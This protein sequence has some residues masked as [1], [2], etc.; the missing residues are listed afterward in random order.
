MSEIVDASAPSV[1]ETGASR[2]NHTNAND[3]RSPCWRYLLDACIIIA[4]GAILFW[5][6]TSQ[7]SNKYNDVT[8]YECYDISFW[9]GNAA[10]Q[11]LGLDNNAKSQCAFLD[12]SSSSTLAQ[13]MQA[14]HFPAFLISLVEAQPTSQAFHALPPEYPLLT[15]AIFSLPLF[16]PTLWYQVIFALLMI[17]AAGVFF[18][19]L[20]RF[21]SL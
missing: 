14:R 12:T 17:I 9:Q 10:L 5:G 4:M 7:F 2:H 18:L 21:P 19:C 15:L 1:D 11:S 6:A 13:K 3:A 16:A 20:P 8:R